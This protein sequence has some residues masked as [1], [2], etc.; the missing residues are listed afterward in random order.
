MKFAVR[1]AP[2]SA[3]LLSAST[4]SLTR[5]R[6]ILQGIPLLTDRLASV[7]IDTLV[8]LHTDEVHQLV[9]DLLHVDVVFGTGLEEMKTCGQKTDI[10][11]NLSNQNCILK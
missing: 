4:A 2:V 11:Q 8:H 10:N 9:E 1:T 5:D 7:A 3:D 6:L